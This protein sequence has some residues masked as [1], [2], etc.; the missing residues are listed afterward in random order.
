LIAEALC[1]GDEYQVVAK[2]LLPVRP[3]RRR[4]LPRQLLA[5][6]LCEGKNY[7][8]RMQILDFRL[9]CLIGVKIRNQ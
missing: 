1:V 9:L 6:A 8:F 3:K 7:Y 5:E 2:L 4:K